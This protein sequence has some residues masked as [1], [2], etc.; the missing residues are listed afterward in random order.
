MQMEMG[1][2]EHVP[3]TR[4]AVSFGVSLALSILVALTIG[5]PTLFTGG[6][7][8]LVAVAGI[9]IGAPLLLV[10]PVLNAVISGCLRLLRRPPLEHPLSARTL[11]GAVLLYAAAWV[12]YGLHVWVLVVDVGGSPLAAL[13][14]SVGAYAVAA[15]L[16][17]LFIVAPAGAG[18]R[19]VLL[20]IGLGPVL[21][22][23]AA[24]AVVVVSRLLVTLAD[25]AAAG[26]SA[27][28]YQRH[29]ARERAPLR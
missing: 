15:T 2:E 1:R 24:T 8:W 19:E 26:L 18:V 29:K 27:F 25:V 21:G 12:A 16:G 14:V 13:P 9:A 22:T 7:N 23:A 5:L 11:W 17:V 3:R 28:G 20:V 4:M 10:P 6:Q